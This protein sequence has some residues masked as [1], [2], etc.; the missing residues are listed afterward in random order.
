VQAIRSRTL[1]PCCRQGLFSRGSGLRQ[2]ARPLEPGGAPAEPHTLMHLGMNESAAS[3]L[4]GRGD[5]AHRLGSATRCR[6]GPAGSGDLVRMSGLCQRR[7]K[8]LVMVTTA[9]VSRPGTIT[10]RGGRMP[11]A[12]PAR[13]VTFT[14]FEPEPSFPASATACR[15]PG[16]GLEAASARMAAVRALARSRPMRSCAR[17]ASREMGLPVAVRWS[18][19]S[20]RL[21]K[22]AHGNFRGHLLKDP[23]TRRCGGAGVTTLRLPKRTVAT[24]QTHFAPEPI[25]AATGW[26]RLLLVSPRTGGSVP[27][28]R[29]WDEVM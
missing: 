13:A 10:P 11:G 9:V 3:R 17:S 25:C 27:T 14:L 23:E 12:S 28:R 4:R 2:P 6:A 20:P 24:G 26:Q 29:R 22:D 21:G 18:A 8:I 19:S 15:D 1:R 5:D 16:S 7:L